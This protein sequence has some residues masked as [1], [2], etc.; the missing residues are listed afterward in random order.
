LLVTA[1]GASNAAFRPLDWTLALLV[2]LI[3]GS[4]YFLIAE[5]IETVAPTTVTFARLV[6]GFA[7]L[8][9][10]PAARRPLAPEDRPRALLLAF[11]WLALPL[12]LFP[13]AEQWVPSALVGMLNGALVIFVAIVATVMLHRLPGRAQM[14]G[15]AVGLVGVVCIGIPSLTGGTQLALGTVLVLV[16][17]GSYAVSANT[18]V[19]L[20]QRYGG[21]ALQRNI[22]RIAVVYVAPLGLWGLRDSSLSWRSGAAL[23]V[24]G[25]MSTGVAAVLASVLLARVGA[26]RGSIYN[27]LIPL[28]SLSEGVAF[29]N[30]HV[31]PLALVGCGLV[32][33]GAFATS[34]AG[35]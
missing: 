31:V 13:I 21:L 16:A 4:S 23:L 8:S 1:E 6:L 9:C 24:L 15:M 12:T 10:V 11:T 30:E 14:L 35:R 34:R 27:Y 19:P 17:L 29:R 7:A 5:S 32:I 20:T 33:V 28:V 18:S 25:I 3:W 26:A 2:S 22:Q